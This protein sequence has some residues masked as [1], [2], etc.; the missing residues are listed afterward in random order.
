M[1]TQDERVRELFGCS[2]DD[3]VTDNM[4]K[5]ARAFFDGTKYEKIWAM[6]Q[7]KRMMGHAS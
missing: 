5:V 3:P 7:L 6:R 4:R 1:P 2:P